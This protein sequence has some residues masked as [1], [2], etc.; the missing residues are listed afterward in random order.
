[1]VARGASLAGG[2]LTTAQVSVVLGKTWVLTFQ[3]ESSEIW[4]ALRDRIRR[5]TSRV[6][7]MQVDHLLHA[8]LDDVVDHYFVA[9]EH[10]EA[11]ADDLE[12]VALRPDRRLDMRAIFE[13]KAQ[14]SDFRRAVWPTRE[15]VAALLRVQDGPIGSSAR[16]YFSDLYDHVVQVMDILENSQERVIGV[17]ELHLAVT[18]HRL[19]DIMK[20]LTIVSTIFIPMTFVAG[21]YGMNFD[22]IPELH[23]QY[24]YAFA[25]ALMLGAAC[26]AGAVVVRRQWLT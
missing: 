5:G 19:N 12:D 18:G 2:A 17:Y 3:E 6:R 8:L 4:N 1:M 23:W 11:R 16:P 26:V 14:L 13:L 22:H 20:V 15:A 9:L 25:W 24:G 7:K 10:F 21:V